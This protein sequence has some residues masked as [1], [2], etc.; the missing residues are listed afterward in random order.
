MKLTEREGIF[1]GGG[2]SSCTIGH[3][4]SKLRRFAQWLR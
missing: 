2:A 4:V 3:I 1:A